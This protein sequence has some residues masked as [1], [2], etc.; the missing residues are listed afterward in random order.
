MHLL[1]ENVVKNLMQLWTGHYKGLDTGSEDYEI[2]PTIWEAIGAASAA[3]GSVLASMCSYV[4]RC[5]G[6]VS[7]RWGG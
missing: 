5:A 1:W 2:D 7:L 3:S 4:H 6:S